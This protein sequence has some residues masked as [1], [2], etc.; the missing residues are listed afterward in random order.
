[1]FIIIV[2]DYDVIGVGTSFFRVRFA[3]FQTHVSL[4]TFFICFFVLFRSCC[5]HARVFG[6]TL[7]HEFPMSYCHTEWYLHFFAIR[8]SLCGQTLRLSK[9]NKAKLVTGCRGFFFSCPLYFFPYSRLFSCF[10]LFLCLYFILAVHMR[11][12]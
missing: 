6:K 2:Y 4:L 9:L 11:E 12:C 7:V 3:S 10:L 1:M 8:N 5:S